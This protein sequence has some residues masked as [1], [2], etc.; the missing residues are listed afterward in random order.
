MSDKD[1]SEFER[2]YNGLF[3][4][5]GANTA[6]M[7]DC[8]EIWNARSAQIAELEADRD[9]HLENNV[10]LAMLRQADAN[11]IAELEAENKR[12]RERE[13]HCVLRLLP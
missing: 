1:T 7:N 13:D 12:L 9:H 5:R 11:R 6:H 8:E 4:L 2:V 3:R 10:R